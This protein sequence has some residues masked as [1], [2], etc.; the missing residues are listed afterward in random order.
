[1]RFV[2]VLLLVCAPAWAASVDDLKNFMRQTQSARA[3]FVQ[4]VL[5]KNHKKI[6]EG[7]GRL[8]FLRPGKFRW[9]YEKPYAQLIVGDGARLW[10]YD[11]DLNQVTVRKL[12]EVIGSSP[13]AL[14]AGSN[15]IEKNFELRVIGGR[16][17]LEWLEAT[18]KVADSTF[19]RV[20][21]GFEDATLAT[22]ELY[23]N[24][25]QV[26][27]IRFSRIERNPKFPPDLFKFVPP[28]GVDV[29]GD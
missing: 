7:K 18:P 22:M 10:L 4:L 19:E 2:M 11:T 16:D 17:G 14:L 12:D 25:E 8:Q 24:F 13:A 26:T 15:E 21:M 29:V 6:Q 5:D 20:R 1:M 9:E 3:D 27:V 28:K 23:D